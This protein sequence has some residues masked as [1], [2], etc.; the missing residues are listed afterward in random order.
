MMLK[1]SGISVTYQSEMEP[2]PISDPSSDDFS[3]GLA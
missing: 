1:S 3:H 2:P